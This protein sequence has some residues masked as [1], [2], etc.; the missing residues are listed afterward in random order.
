MH[1]TAAKCDASYED[2]ESEDRPARGNRTAG[3]SLAD[4]VTF[5]SSGGI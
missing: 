2:G 5:E 4:G 3:S 1:R